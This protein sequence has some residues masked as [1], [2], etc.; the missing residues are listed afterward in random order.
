MRLNQFF[1][2]VWHLLFFLVALRSEAMK[3]NE[4]LNSGDV[5]GSPTMTP[6]MCHF[7]WL[8]EFMSQCQADYE[9]G[10]MS[11]G[12]IKLLEKM[13]KFTITS[14]QNTQRFYI[15]SGTTEAADREALTTIIKELYVSDPI[16]HCEFNKVFSARHK[17]ANTIRL[18]VAD[19]LKRTLTNMQYFPATKELSVRSGLSKEIKKTI[20]KQNFRHS[21]IEEIHHAAQSARNRELEKNYKSEFDNSLALPF[22]SIGE[23]QQLTGILKNGITKVKDLIQHLRTKPH[24]PEAMK[25]KLLVKNYKPNTHLLGKDS[26]KELYYSTWLQKG[27]IDTHFNLKK[28]FEWPLT[29]DAQ[30]TLTIRIL[31]VSDGFLSFQFVTAPSNKPLIALL[32]FYADISITLLKGGVANEE[33]ITKESAEIDAHAHR[34]YQTY[35]EMMDHLFPGLRNYHQARMGQEFQQC[36]RGFRS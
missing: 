25:F 2:G 14:T 13:P 30:T 17:K 36:L 18:S 16:F 23:S 3:I 21:F 12:Q 20:N 28:Q 27:Y 24:H 9:S 35:P 29:I 6:V 32:D 31:D 11:K 22:T 5:L 33:S 26:A 4:P 7:L 8:S 1:F 34:F 15:N 19:D 10:F